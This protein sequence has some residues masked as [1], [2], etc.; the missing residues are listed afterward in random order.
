[1]IRYKIALITLLIVVTICNTIAKEINYQHKQLN[2]ELVKAWNV[3]VSV[4]KELTELSALSINEGKFFIVE[5]NGKTLGYVYIGRIKSC[6]AGGCAIDKTMPF[7]G[8][9]EY[10]DAFVLFNEN[11]T[12]N[13]VKVFN[14]QATHGHEVCSRG[15]LKQFIGY[16]AENPLNVGKD[17]DS[18][19]GATISVQALTDEINYISQ[20]LKNG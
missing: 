18:I 2:K 15:W 8:A 13:T 4:L 5:I 12:V 11:K 16:N 19:S 9:Y 1:M 6:R 17:I 14:Y 10:F 20:L 3:D 7:D